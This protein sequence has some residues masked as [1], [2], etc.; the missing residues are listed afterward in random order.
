MMD[1]TNPYLKPS[2][3]TKRPSKNIVHA[4]MDRQ[5]TGQSSR[6]LATTVEQLN[7][8]KARNKL[9][10]LADSMPINIPEEVII[11][12]LGLLFVIFIVWWLMWLENQMAK[13]RDGT[14]DP[15]LCSMYFNMNL[16]PF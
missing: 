1:F 3:G 8:E 11:F 7:I 6:Q 5:I 9:D 12:V 2:N 16:A 14:N 4:L 13:C 15:V 10:Q